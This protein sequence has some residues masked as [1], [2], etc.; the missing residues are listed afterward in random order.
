M[1]QWKIT[2]TSSHGCPSPTGVCGTYWTSDLLTEAVEGM[3]RHVLTEHAGITDD[4]GV[5]VAKA[6]S[7]YL[8][9]P[10]S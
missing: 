5:T 1:D 6:T 8:L 9:R 2:C 4:E 7:T 10:R 3:T